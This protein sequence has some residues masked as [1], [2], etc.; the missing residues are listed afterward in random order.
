MASRF[1][2]GGTGTWNASSTANWSATSG[3]A[4]GASAP[5]T[6]D[7]VTFDSN[8]G[9]GTV[10]TATGSICSTSTINSANISL[11][12]GGNH[13][14]SG[15][16]TLT[17]G[18]VSLA[19]YSVT[20]TAFSSSNS[21][22]RLLNFG[23][24][25]IVLSGSNATVF[26]TG[27]FT[28]MTISGSRTVELSYSGAVGT[29]TITTASIAAGNTEAMVVSFYILSGTDIVNISSGRAYGTIDFTGFAGSFTSN[30]MSVY[31]NFSISS[32]MTTVASTGAL[33]FVATSGT[34]TITTNGKTIDQPIAFNGIGGTFACSDALTQ[35][36]TR[37][38]TITNGTVQLK[39][40]VTSTVGLFATSG[41]NQ[42]YLQSTLAGS[43]ATL[44]QATGTVD[45]SY[46]TIQDINATGGAT[47]N[48]FVDQ[49]NI[50]AGNVDG[51]N[52]GI[53]PVI[54]GSEYTYQL[55]SF[56]QPRRF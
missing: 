25:K 26:N 15:S 51:W 34:K 5:T 29:R 13:T 45:S 3:G 20:C 11:V 35:G 23:T 55:R 17:I 18:S 28:G 47:W 2:V 42:K 8:S 56:T 37:A 49:N 52:F 16:M 48:A 7:A 14:Q 46:L 44:S 36:S 32:G 9:T 21:N 1:W 40:G 53:S 50:D 43:Q 31:G 19:S 54:G 41:S 33:G 6:S 4:S 12:F 39:A 24:G 10:T 22:T 30:S 38:F 27:T